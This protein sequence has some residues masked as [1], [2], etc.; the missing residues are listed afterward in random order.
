M[1]STLLVFAALLFVACPP[2]QQDPV[3]PAPNP[4]PDSDVVDA[5]CNHLQ[6]LGCEEGKPVYNDNLP[7]PVD[8]PNQSCGDFY[9]E[10]QTQ[11]VF[12]NPRCVVKVPDCSSIEDYRAKQPEAC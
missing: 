2:V 6:E 8:V 3:V 5:M 11:G 7:G 10:L 9:R 12:V 4:P 1:R